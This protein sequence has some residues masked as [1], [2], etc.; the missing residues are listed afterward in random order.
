[1]HA[2][3]LVRKGTLGSSSDFSPVL[4]FL[5][6]DGFA[7]RNWP[8]QFMLVWLTKILFKEMN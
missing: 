8:N 2:V 4:R 7:G 6:K 5:T 1:L 3:F